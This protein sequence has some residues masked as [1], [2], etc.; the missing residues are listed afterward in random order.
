MQGVCIRNELLA[1]VSSAGSFFVPTNLG[2]KCNG[3]ETLKIA[4]SGIYWK[5]SQ[6]HITKKTVYDTQAR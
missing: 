4:D 1:G 5:E 2:R 3:N 6:L